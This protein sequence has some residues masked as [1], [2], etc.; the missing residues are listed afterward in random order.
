MPS[1]Y[2][3]NNT[4]KMNHIAANANESQPVAGPR[5]CFDSDP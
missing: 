4:G 2:H 3:F 1:A 5:L